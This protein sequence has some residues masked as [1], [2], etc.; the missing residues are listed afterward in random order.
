MP[1]RVHG[2]AVYSSQDAEATSVFVGRWLGEE[3]VVQVRNA[4]LLSHRKER[5][6]A[7]CTNMG[8][9]GGYYA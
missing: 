5:K 1:P 9:P 6:F 4:T 2:S 8:G 7:V 3:D